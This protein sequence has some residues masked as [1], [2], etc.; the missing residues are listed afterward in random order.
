MG[1]EFSI[2]EKCGVRPPCF[3][4]KLAKAGSWRLDGS[5]I[6]IEQRGIND[7]FAPHPVDGLISLFRVSD[8]RELLRVGIG[9]NSMRASLTEDLYM[10]AIA[11]DELGDAKMID[12]AGDTRCSLANRVHLNIEADMESRERLVRTLIAAKRKRFK[13][14][15]TIMKGVVE[16]ARAEGCHAVC[17]ESASCLCEAGTVT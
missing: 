15:S 7:V 6:E 10:L 1:L 3:V 12:A 5:A 9:V 4:R 16:E 14:T 2:Q 11:E 8:S 13:I 17:D